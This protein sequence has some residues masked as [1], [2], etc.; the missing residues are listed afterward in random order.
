MSRATCRIR[1]KLART[2]R[3]VALLS[4]TAMIAACT[5][6][7]RKP[8]RSAGQVRAEV[9]HLL[10]AQA[11]AREAWADAVT[12]AFFALDIE[13]STAH[14]CAALAVAEQESNFVADPEVPG[15]G[16]IAREEIARRAQAHHVPQ[17]VL[18]AA[19]AI[20]SSNGRS[21]ADRIAAAR[22]ERE[23][24]LVYEDL[25]DRVPLGQRLFA[26]AN[27]VKTAGP[28]QVS[29][30]FAEQFARTH[31]YPYAR[32]QDDPLRHEVFTLRGGVYFGIAHLLGH[33]VSYDRMLYR[34]ADYNAGFYASRNA[35]F[36]N[37]V[38]VASGKRLTLDGDLIDY[39]GG[40]GQ[41]EL[42]LQTLAGALDLSPAQIHRALER[43]ESPDLETTDVYARLYALA[44]KRASAPL[45]R[46]MLPQIDLSSPKIT[47]KLTTQWFAE[48]VQ[49]RYRACL[50]RAE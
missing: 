33:P 12:D 35:A 4:A 31:R 15:L 7:P 48:R 10:P 41:T 8:A 44:D 5:A 19:L 47:R 28:M 39:D 24:S 30:T 26:D 36:Q 38:S 50:A 22:T 20:H 11:H 17:L 45:P 42:A 23:L 37:A 27:P 14:L 21:Y 40:T 16:R 46:A 49:Q 34:F 6:P 32:V 3:F 25:I 18:D 1:R 29:V 43:G 9:L 2:T 13:P